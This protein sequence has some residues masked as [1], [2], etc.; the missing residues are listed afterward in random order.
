MAVFV[1]VFR[2]FAVV[3]TGSL[4]AGLRWLGEALA[5]TL[6][7]AK[8]VVGCLRYTLVP[9]ST[10]FGLLRSLMLIRVAIGKL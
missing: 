2:E 4:A 3:L 7:V 9:T 10:L 8:T 6:W 1:E 5:G